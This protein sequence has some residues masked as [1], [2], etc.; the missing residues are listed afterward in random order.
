MGNIKV[1]ATNTDALRLR[2]L[3][4]VM[5]LDDEKLCALHEAMLLA[6]E[7]K[8]PVLYHLLHTSADEL[9]EKESIYTHKAVM[10]EIEDEMGWK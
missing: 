10:D 3:Q 8:N 5:E 2:V 4:E 7:K 1:K 6:S 9:N